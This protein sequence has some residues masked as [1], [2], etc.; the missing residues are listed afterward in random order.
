M[1][2][3]TVSLTAIVVLIYAIYILNPPPPRWLIGLIALS[4]IINASI[5]VSQLIYMIGKQ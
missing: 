5:V 2:S 1:L 3:L 4:I